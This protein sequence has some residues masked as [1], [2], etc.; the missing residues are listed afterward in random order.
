MLISSKSKVC[1][2][3]DVILTNYYKC[4]RFVFIIFFC[5]F[6]IGIELHN[7]AHFEGNGFLEFNRDLLDHSDQSRQE[8]IAFELS[9]NSSDGLIFWHGQTPEQDG[10]GQDFIALAGKSQKNLTK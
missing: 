5:V 2:K 6:F 7:D 8:V 9:T 10:I 3:N 1:R 4:Q